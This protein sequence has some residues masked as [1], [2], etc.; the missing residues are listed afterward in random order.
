MPVCDFS[1]IPYSCPAFR[2][3][4]SFAFASFASFMVIPNKQMKTK[5]SRQYRPLV[6]GTYLSSLQSTLFDHPSTQLLQFLLFFFIGKRFD[7]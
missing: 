2:R 3:M 6:I 5:V 1:I 7:L 4:S